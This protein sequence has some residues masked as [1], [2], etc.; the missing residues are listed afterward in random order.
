M[1]TASCMICQFLEI[2]MPARLSQ[3]TRLLDSLE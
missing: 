1:F 2:F 3:T